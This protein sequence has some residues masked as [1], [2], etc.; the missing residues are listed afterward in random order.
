MSEKPEIIPYNSANDPFAIFSP[1][2]PG[3]ARLVWS[4][5][6]PTTAEGRVALA[7]TVTEERKAIWENVPCV[8]PIRDVVLYQEYVADPESGEIGLKTRVILVT[9]DGEVYGTSS[10]V[11]LSYLSRIVSIIGNP[12]W[13][14][15]LRVEFRKVRTSGGKWALTATLASE[16]EKPDPESNGKKG[17]KK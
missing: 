12:P 6:S 11:V 17:G 7:R 2:S 13:R 3:S 4:S 16:P 9:T 1:E 15:G 8:L 5:F 14:D 10:P